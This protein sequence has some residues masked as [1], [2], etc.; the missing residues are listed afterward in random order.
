M[1]IVVVVLIIVVVAIVVI[2]TV[3]TVVVVVEVF[4]W[5]GIFNFE[6]VDE[7]AA[8]CDIIPILVIL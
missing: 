1:V 3:V 6:R 4:E 5:N 8:A 7:L 2:V